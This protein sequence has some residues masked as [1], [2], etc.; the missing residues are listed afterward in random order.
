MKCVIL[1]LAILLSACCTST[2][3]SSPVTASK[4]KSTQ[5]SLEEN[6]LD[7]VAKAIALAK[8]NKDYRLMVTSGRSIS[9]PGVNSGEYQ[10]KIELCGKKYNS[11]TGDVITSPAQRAERKKHIN[12]M[13]Q[14]NKQMLVICQENNNK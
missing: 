11:V 7:S 8:K 2:S 5:L 10:A 6:G 1:I 14:Y 12:F 4:D 9:I 3:T 13:R